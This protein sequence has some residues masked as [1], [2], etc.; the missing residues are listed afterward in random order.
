[1]KKMLNKNLQKK[2]KKLSRNSKLSHVS[3][4]R[5][6]CAKLNKINRVSLSLLLLVVTKIPTYQS[7]K[8]NNLNFLGEPSKVY[9]IWKK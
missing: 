2:K 4:F 8:V 7:K 3:F 6:R 9:L 1:M 5:T